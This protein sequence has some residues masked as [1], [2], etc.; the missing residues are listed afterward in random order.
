MFMCFMLSFKRISMR[1]IV[2]YLLFFVL[3]PLSALSQVEEGDY[4]VIKCTK[5]VF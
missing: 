4:I 3:F 5:S 1:G 2:C